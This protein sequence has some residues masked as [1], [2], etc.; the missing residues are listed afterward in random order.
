MQENV[1]G[2]GTGRVAVAAINILGGAAGW[3]SNPRPHSASQI[4]SENIPHPF[5]FPQ[6]FGRY[7]EK[8]ILSVKTRGNATC[9]PKKYVSNQHHG[10]GI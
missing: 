6:D 3:P 9:E 2:G 10:R 1:Y 5:I 7:L 4:S 8:C